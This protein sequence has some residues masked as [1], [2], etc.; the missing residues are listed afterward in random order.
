MASWEE[1]LSQA[2]HR[3]TAPRRAVMEVLMATQ[4]PLS[5]QEIC[6]RGQA[7]H[8]SL[9]LVTVYRTLELFE[10]FD[11]AR[12]VHLREGCHGYIATSPG[13]RHTILC[14]ACGRSVEFVGQ[15]D[16]DDLIARVEARTGYEVR[17][18]LLQLFG[19][20]PDCREA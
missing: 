7:H 19:L 20:C 10:R 12:R 1:T 6:T 16:L 9:G 14:R 4:A 11:L 17:D 8:G 13:H 3:I 15:D 18:H 5:P 2:G